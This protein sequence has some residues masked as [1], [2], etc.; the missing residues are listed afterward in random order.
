M[1]EDAS[2][3][4]GITRELGGAQ[5]AAI[6]L[7]VLGEQEASK[8]LQHMSPDELQNLGEAMTNINDVSQHDIFNVM[9]TFADDTKTKTPLDIGAYDYLK[10]AHI[11][12]S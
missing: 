9:M 3:D 6:L 8:V 4:A 12:I 2:L 11:K 7:M 5:R 1:A 10:K